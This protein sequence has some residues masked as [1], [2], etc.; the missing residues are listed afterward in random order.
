VTAAAA[1]FAA[2]FAAT[3]G[4][5]EQRELLVCP[6]TLDPAWPIGDPADSHCGMFC[7]PFSFTGQPAV[8]VPSG[9][10]HDGVPVGVQL[11]GRAGS[12]EA[13][14]A[15]AA[16]LQ[17]VIGWTAWRPGRLDAEP[18]LPGSIAAG[19]VAPGR[20]DPRRSPGGA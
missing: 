14:L 13:L 3:P 2:A 11:V 12:D 6:V 16:E 10:F 19:T 4:W 17:T 7:L 15:L 18:G 5:W 8:V 1:T 20:L 9:V